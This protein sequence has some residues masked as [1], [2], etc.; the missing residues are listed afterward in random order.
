[1]KKLFATA[2]LALP[3]SAFAASPAPASSDAW[4]GARP[5]V[6]ISVSHGESPDTYQVNAVVSD[7]RNGTVLAEPVM[8][9]QAGKVARAEI[10]GIGA[11]GLASVAFAVT[12]DPAGE[13][14]TYASEVRNNAEVVSSQSATLA[15]VE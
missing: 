9:V 7:L 11:E 13:T 4:Q 8:L 1:M 3:F 5:A 2:L 12:V 10:G 6:E 15:V 14:A